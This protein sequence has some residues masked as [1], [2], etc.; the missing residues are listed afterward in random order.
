V[1]LEQLFLNRLLN[2]AQAVGRVGRA[3]IAVDID[4][5]NVR[6]SVTDTGSGIS[7]ENLERIQDPFFS[8]KPDG[9]GLGLSIARRIA[10]AHGGSLWIESAVGQGTRVEVRLP[11]AVAPGG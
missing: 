11:L 5:P 4:E 10:A 7:K 3:E 9:N 1:A 2:S 8:T 6:I